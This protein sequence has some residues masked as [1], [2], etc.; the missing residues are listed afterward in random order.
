LLSGYLYGYQV[1]LK[2]PIL[3][4]AQSSKIKASK[5]GMSAMEAGL[6]DVQFQMNS[7]RNALE[8]ELLKYREHITY[9]QNEGEALSEA[10]L[11]TAESSYKN[12][13]IDFF[14]YILSVENAFQIEL[15][16]LEQLN[17]YNQTVIQ[18]NYLSI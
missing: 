17:N 12:G 9:Y 18:L 2:I 8:K 13:E 6:K 14:Q 3:F 4:G 15:D 16:Y 10:I 5:I 1:G 7:K 11:K